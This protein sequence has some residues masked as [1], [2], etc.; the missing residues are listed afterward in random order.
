MAKT[1]ML[2]PDDEGA[3]LVDWC[4]GATYEATATRALLE[5]ARRYKRQAEREANLRGVAT[6]RKERYQARREKVREA[7]YSLMRL[8]DMMAQEVRDWG[9]EDNRQITIGRT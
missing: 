5:A 3:N 2:R 4:K 9:T 1:L 8:S 6:K 7:G